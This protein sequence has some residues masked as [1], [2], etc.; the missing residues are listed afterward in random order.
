V[1]ASG[2]IKKYYGELEENANT[3]YA[4][5]RK[6]RKKGLDCSEEVEILPALDVAA[7]VEGLTGP[8]GIASE[9]RSLLKKNPSRE[10]AA[11]KI[12]ES[13]IEG[14]FK[15]VERGRK[16]LAEQCIRTALALL[17]EG[18]VAAPLEGISDV[19]IE[20]NPDGSEYISVYFAG[21]IRS[22]GGTAQALAV[23]VADYTRKLLGL[24]DFRPT[25]TE[26]ERYVEEISMYHNVVVRLQYKPSDDEVRTIVSNCP[27][28][29]S[30]DPTAEVEVAVYRDLERMKTNRIR[31]G[32]CLVIGEGIAQKAQKVVKYAKKFSLDWRW[33]QAVIKVEKAREGG[34]PEIKPNFTYLKDI[35]AGRPVFA[36]PSTT[37]G[38]RLRYGR[39]RNTGIMAKGV[40]PATMVILGGFPAIGTQ[41]KLERP[42][43]GAAI[44]S[45]DSIDGPVVLLKDGSVVK[46]ESKGQAE[47][48][49][50]EVKEVLFLGDLL[51]CFG[52]FLHANH[53]LMPAGFCEEWWVQLLEK[54]GGKC[55]NPY[56]V[57]VEEAFGLCEKYGVP[58]HPEY[59]F[60]YHDLTS[61]E[62][63]DLI[64]W[65]SKGDELEI[66]AEKRYLEKLLVPHHL[67]DGRVI[68]EK[69]YKDALFKTLD[70]PVEEDRIEGMRE[71]KPMQ[72]VNRLS[73]FKIMRKSPTYIGARMGRPEKANKRMMTPAPHI[74]FPLGQ[75]GGRGR[76]FAKAMESRTISVEMVRM[77]C[78]KCGKVLPNK[79]KCTK[80]GGR[81]EIEKV[82]PKCG[83]TG[84]GE[85]C[86]ACG[87][88]AVD[89]DKRTINIVDL[90]DEASSS[91]G[92]SPSDVFKG[93][94][95]LVSAKKMFEPLEKGI[96][97]SKNG[98][99]VF[100]DGTVRFDATNLPLTHFKP[101]EIGVT[102]KRLKK[103]GYLKDIEGKDLKNENQVVELKPQDI[104]ISEHGV[105]YFMAV[106]SFIDELLVNFYGLDSFYNVQTKED[107][108]GHLVIGLAPHTSAGVLG[109]II[110]FNRAKACF[111]HPYFHQAKR[112]DSDGDEDSTILL[113]DALLNFSR[114]YLP[115]SRGGQ[116][117]ASLVL[118]LR[119]I[120]SE[121]DN[122]VHEMEIV[123]NYSLNFYEKTIDNANPSDVNMELVKHRLDRENQYNDF[124]FTH[125]TGD[126]NEGVLSSSY[127]TL[128]TMPEK[129][130]AQLGL[131]E[132]IMAVDVAD[133]ATRLLSSHFLRDIYGNLRSFGEQ[134]FRCVDCNAKY[135]RVP[136]VGKCTRCGGKIILTIAEGSVRK[137][138]EISG[139]IAR[140]YNLS[141]YMIQRL[142]LVERDIDS[143]FVND[144]SKQYSLSEFI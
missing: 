5:A 74:L 88:P 144:K 119:I 126:I 40:H 44:T 36:Y 140:K 137:Y 10:M 121:V 20:K 49:E 12:V 47:K 89:F 94:M 84:K 129:I 26:V 116:M 34:K 123:K 115:A 92:S 81:G 138:L 142:K 59:T 27:V 35:V 96:L 95:G 109:R 132:R 114:S 69:V 43:K 111:A 125:D 97:R 63:V 108:L 33:L 130:D 29:I 118:T 99:F 85:K 101:K 55:G 25:D 7:R 14:K 50:K 38:F 41:L 131:G 53:A 83:R 141:D 18:V 22:A 71:K 91:V 31:G 78:P 39:A 79:Y 9:I 17:T 128:R 51:V 127:T 113:L 6:A 57:S 2:E 72:I 42:G 37:G 46:V 13:I 104:I 67:S 60:P 90:L 58:L 45:C 1:K 73:P 100:K 66:G 24:E 56:E 134:Q 32:M 54:A 77:V 61:D 21:P 133:E 3:V 65:L 68:I 82:C 86:R 75:Y 19:T 52:D 93:V 15:S 80:C 106:T 76:S 16:S 107:L 136:L 62:L 117:D 8:P 112:R 87:I 105:E 98:V 30:G 4:L 110:G 139:E 124:G 102:V 64:E 23:L 103:I 143:V 11:L 70:I 135:R 122:Q 120:P 48:I 28:C